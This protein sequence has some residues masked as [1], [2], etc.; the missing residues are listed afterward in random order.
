MLAA[1]ALG[2]CASG[3][4]VR[5]VE[6]DAAVAAITRDATAQA[7]L[8]RTCYGCHASGYRL[9][10]RERFAYSYWFR[11]SARK[12]L[13]FTRWDGLSEEQRGKQLHAIGDAVEH[14]HMPPWD[15]K[16][17]D[18]AAKLTPAE[19]EALLRFSRHET[20]S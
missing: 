1:G 16:L 11:G 14:G 13:D 2:A 8:E 18:G 5:P 10:G 7:A 4:L 9:S 20:R 3:G 15:A 19:R 6:S 12:A 17:F